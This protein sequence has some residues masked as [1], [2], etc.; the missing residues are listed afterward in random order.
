MYE[1]HNLVIINIKNCVFCVV[2]LI[3]DEKVGGIILIRLQ[4]V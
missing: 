2:L 1:N 4:L 3:V